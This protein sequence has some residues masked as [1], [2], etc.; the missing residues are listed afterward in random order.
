MATKTDYS[1][2]LQ[3]VQGVA[4]ADPSSAIRAN[5]LKTKAVGEA[6]GAVGST[7][8][9][10][11]KGYQEEGVRQ[12]QQTLFGE[13]KGDFD[14]LKEAEVVNNA[15][16]EAAVKTPDAVESFRREQERIGQAI[17]Q[18]PQRAAE[19][20]MR[21]SKALREAIARNPGLANSFRQVTHEITGLKD[22]DTYSVTNLYDE[23]DL[24]AKRQQEAA[25]A[26][27]KA[28]EDGLK[29]FLKDTSNV[30]SE[31]E[32]TTVY[33]QM[34]PDQRLQTATD[35]FK[36]EQRMKA[37]KAS[38][39]QGGMAVQNGVTHLI[40]GADTG[41]VAL[42]N[43]ARNKLRDAGI[44]ETLLTTGQLTEQM[45][46]N[47]KLQPILTEMAAIHKGYLENAFQS[48][49]KQITAALQNGS[50]D[51]T[52]GRNALKDLQSWYTQRVEE[53]DK[54]G[55]MKVLGAL[56]GSDENDPQKT[57]D[58]RLRTVNLI[59]TSLNIPPEIATQFAQGDPKVTENIRRSYPQW[60]RA[61]DHMDEL[62][63]AALR[64]ATSSEW[65]DLVK[66]G[67]ELRSNPTVAIPSDKMSL[68][69]T[70]IETADATKKMQDS[71]M[72][73]QSDIPST[74]KVVSGAMALRDNAEKLLKENS[75]ALQRQLS[76]MPASEKAAFDTQV[77]QSYENVV[78]GPV[79]HGDTAKARFDAAVGKYDRLNSKLVFIDSQGTQPL[80]VG[81]VGKD[82]KTMTNYSGVSLTGD[83]D[84]NKA[85]ASVDSAI[86]VYAMT[87][88]QD[89]MKLRQEFMATFMKGK[90]SEVYTSAVS[91]ASVAAA[92][93]AGGSTPTPSPAPV[94]KLTKESQL[95]GA[96]QGG[97]QDLRDTIAGLE[98]NLADT[99]EGSPLY[100]RTKADIEAAK[101]E[102]KRLVGK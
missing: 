38:I 13:L 21:S 39:E 66:K 67:A 2:Q 15:T 23:I 76:L 9:D 58:T 43:A 82:T 20:R 22:L 86:R 53:I 100:N 14:A 99:K 55:A 17:S 30:M 35:A 95:P 49:T 7:L 25:K 24:V 87:T 70:V 83:D 62:R 91:N 44:D 32:A 65:F 92:K 31:T 59:S 11:Y 52:A 40:A 80:K 48:G 41:N 16:F 96:V 90:P 72:L 63:R 61:F 84:V 4:A 28:Y 85:L 19:W 42:M 102:L 56:V 77:R 18:M 26:Q 29:S 27:A 75:T 68:T 78:F 57:M 74:L 1:A 64:G 98:S 88:G 79:G 93:P 89:V 47:P 73:G 3:G 37:F 81:S 36:T 54:S 69:A 45:K 10:V 60:G 71:A 50:V 94:G 33:A 51:P 34:T 5:Q 46:T 101:A 97:V 8:F 6:I 12:E